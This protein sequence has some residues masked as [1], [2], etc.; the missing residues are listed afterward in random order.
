MSKRADGQRGFSLSE[1]LVVLAILGLAVAIAVPL[2]AEA[3]RSAKARGAADQFAVDLRA[4]RM[5][6]V[7]Q[8]KDIPVTVSTATQSY[9]YEVTTGGLRQIAMPDGVQIVASTTPITFLKNGSVQAASTTVF[10][11]QLT[12]GD[13]E[14][15]TVT[16][17]TLGVVRTTRARVSS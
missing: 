3:V 12:G 13:N 6:A 1:L 17:N 16:A 2:V 11:T 14:Q 8:R 7:T 15:F 10:Q 5:I 4:A 9:Q